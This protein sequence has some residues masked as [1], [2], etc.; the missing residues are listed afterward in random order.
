MLFEETQQV[1]FHLYAI[2]FGKYA[3]IICAK[4]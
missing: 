3:K 4:N 2:V 1:S